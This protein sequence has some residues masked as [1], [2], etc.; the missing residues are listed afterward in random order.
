MKELKIFGVVASFTLLLYWGVEPYAHSILHPHVAPA[1]FKFKDLEPVTA[2]GDVA[3]GK[4]LVTQN[5]TACHSITSQGFGAPLDNATA[6]MSYGVVPPD[7]SSTGKIYDETFLAH[8]IKD[9]AAAAKVQHKFEGGQSHPMPG[10]GWMSDEDINSMVEYFKS[11]APAEMTNEEVFVDACGRCHDMK[12]S[13]NFADSDVSEYMGSTPPDLSMMIRSRG[14]DYLTVFVNDP[15]KNLTETAM[16]RVGLNESAQHQVVTYLEEVGDSKKAEREGLA[17]YV[18][19]FLA[20]MTLVSFLWKK[21]IW[22]EV[23]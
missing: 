23:K 8:F 19:G 18:L 5:C 14:F 20:F 6:N 16:P 7:L 15:Q 22:A 11:I 17:P 4:E 2:K 21:E 10:Y 1:D 13:K 12:Y 9:P 3:K